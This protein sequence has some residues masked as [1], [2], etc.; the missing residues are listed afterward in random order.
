M[1]DA[2]GLS[3]HPVDVGIRSEGAILGELSKLG[4]DVLSPFSYNHRYDF[5]IDLGDRF[6]KAQC[7]TGRARGG[8]I[9]FNKVSARCSMTAV[10]RRSYDN[11]VDLFLVYYPPLDKVYVLPIADILAGVSNLRVEPPGNGRR[12]GVHWAADYCLGSG[13]LARAALPLPPRL[14]LAAAPE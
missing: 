7:K 2:T 1:F 5:V 14:T 3:T 13:D 9:I 6:V 4:Y 12:K 10:H 11:D 8:A